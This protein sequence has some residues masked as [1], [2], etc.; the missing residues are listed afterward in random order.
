[1]LLYWILLEKRKGGKMCASNSLTKQDLL[2]KL[3]AAVSS[4]LKGD[5]ELL[6]INVSERSIS[7]KLACYIDCEF[8]QGLNFD[9]SV[10]AEYI[11]GITWN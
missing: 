6:E 4:F 8:K 1:M 11:T 2:I 7:S 10:D 3:S 9:I 5:S